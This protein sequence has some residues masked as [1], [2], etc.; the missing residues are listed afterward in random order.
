MPSEGRVQMCLGGDW[1]W[2]VCGGSDQYAYIAQVVCRQLRYQDT[3]QSIGTKVR[4]I[5]GSLCM[6]YMYMYIR[7]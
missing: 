4:T 5:Y 7:A 1:W 6:T 2:E 3:G